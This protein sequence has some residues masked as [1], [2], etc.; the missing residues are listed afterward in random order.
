VIRFTVICDWCGKK[1]EWKR[2]ADYGLPIGWERFVDPKGEHHCC[3]FAHAELFRKAFAQWRA[4]LAIAYDTAEA[5]YCK[6]HPEP[7]SHPK[8]DAC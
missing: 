6:N 1:T 8:E 4:G 7:G 5:I 2:D 3:S